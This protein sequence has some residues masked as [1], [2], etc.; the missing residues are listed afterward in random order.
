LEDHVAASI[1]DKLKDQLAAAKAEYKDK[2]ADLERQIV[3]LDKEYGAV[4]GMLDGKGAKRGPK[5]GKTNGS[6]EYGGV[7]EAVLA[8][9]TSAKNGIKPAQIAA[10]TGL[11]SPQ[12]H[13]SLTGL[14]KSKDVR[15]K[16]GLYHAT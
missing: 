12:V 16:D 4:F 9:I 2:R 7:K 11:A 3:A 15:V 14:K 1:F 6:R 5:A 8:A 13:N 10:K